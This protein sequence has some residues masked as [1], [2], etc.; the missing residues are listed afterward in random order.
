MPKKDYTMSH[1]I[2]IDF[3]VNYRPTCRL[4]DRQYV[5][6]ESQ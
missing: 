5:A 4:I 2:L 6:S 3:V 1:T